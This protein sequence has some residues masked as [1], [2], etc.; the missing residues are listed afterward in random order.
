ML[1][2]EL[3]YADVGFCSRSNCMIGSEAGT[4]DERELLR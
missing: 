3:L 4:A 1:A 2:L